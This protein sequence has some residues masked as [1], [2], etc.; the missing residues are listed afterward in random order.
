MLLVIVRRELTSMERPRASTQPS[1]RSLLLRWSTV[2]LLGACSEAFVAPNPWSGGRSLATP[3]HAHIPKAGDGSPDL[4]DYFHALTNGQSGGGQMTIMS[5]EGTETG[6][7]SDGGGAGETSIVNLDADR[8]LPP[9]PLK[10]VKDLKVELLKLAC[11]SDRGRLLDSAGRYRAASL[12]QDL[13]MQNPTAD[14]AE[15]PLLQGRWTLVYS[16]DDPTRSSPFF[17]AFRKA[18]AGVKVS[19]YRMKVS[20]W[21]GQLDPCG[22][23]QSVHH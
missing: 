19:E 13:E 22:T 15:S 4:R 17:W 6:S 2:A 7:M 1:R 5:A 11:Q 23:E 12:L 8:S 9:P 16:T 21:C 14:P 20:P 10:E 3:P 18:L